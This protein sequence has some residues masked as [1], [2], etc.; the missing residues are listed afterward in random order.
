MFLKRYI[1]DS[2]KKALPELWTLSILMRQL[3]RIPVRSKSI[4]V[5]DHARI[6]RTARL[7]F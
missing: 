3:L 5:T 1:P 6:E 7:S 2:M 4:N